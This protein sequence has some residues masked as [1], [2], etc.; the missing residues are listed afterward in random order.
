MAL[1]EVKYIWKLIKTQEWCMILPPSLQHLWQK[2]QALAR[3]GFIKEQVNEGYLVL[4]WLVVNEK[5][6]FSFVVHVS[7][8]KRKAL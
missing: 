2:L 8:E 7:V 1:M 3:T 4:V 5:Y 6:K